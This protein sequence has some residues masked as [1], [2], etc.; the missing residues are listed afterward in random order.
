MTALLV[1]TPAPDRNESLPGYV[2]RLSE[3][4]G[5]DTPWHL[6]SFVGIAPSELKLASFPAEELAALGV[7][8]EALSRVAYHREAEGKHQYS[9]LGHNLGDG[10]S[11]T[12]LRISAPAICPDCAAEQGF[13]EAFFDLNI[14]TA[15]PVHRRAVVTHCPS[16]AEP[17]SHFRPGLLTCRCGASLADAPPVEVS[18]QVVSLMSILRSVLTGEEYCN[19]GGLP[20]E[21]LLRTSLRML[22]VHLPSFARLSRPEASE[23]MQVVV[24]GIA[25][26]LADWPTG[27]HRLLRQIDAAQ[28]EHVVAFHKR[29]KVL[30]G[31]FFNVPATRDAFD[32]LH[33]EFLRYGCEVSSNATVHPRMLRAVEVDRRFVSLKEWA[34]RVGVMPSTAGDW[35]RKGLIAAKVIET[36]TGPR[37]VVDSTKVETPLEAA[38]GRVLNAREAAAHLGLTVS[39]LASL[40]QSEH[41]QCKHRLTIKGGYHTADLDNFLN[42]LLELSP[43]IEDTVATDDTVSLKHALQSYRMHCDD[44]KAG[45]VAAYLDGDLRSVGRTGE[46]TT[47]ILFRREDLEALVL[48]SRRD[49]AGGALTQREAAKLLGSDST[50]IPGLLA[51][52]WLEAFEARE[53]TRVTAVSVERFARHYIAISRLAKEVAT[54]SRRLMGLCEKNGIPVLSIS[55]ETGSIAPFIERQHVEALTRLSEA[56]PTREDLAAAR[57][58]GGHPAV[59]A[60]RAYLEGLKACGEQLPLR[61]GKPN[62]VAIARAC[63]FARD[64]L[65]DNECAI[66]LLN[67]HLR[68]AEGESV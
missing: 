18:D 38:E 6:L 2:L 21:Q 12:P 42:R 7:P 51:A 26:V 67:A 61:G 20:A 49:A 64:V 34:E 44:R 53:S 55:R 25:E 16:C 39:A 46:T 5:Y 63:G 30:C 10:L 56:N 47:D 14:A 32:W 37:Y 62:K 60:L 28:P 27:F 1:R 52:G 45:L 33:E 41:F 43:R 48:S 54:S 23:E 13:I 3:A 9:L 58:E 50:V 24:E 35:A 66:E 4:N 65:Y 68:G 36:A 40:K 31:L 19:P 8:R 57:A 29:F 11:Y 17:L 22:L 15:C 59:E